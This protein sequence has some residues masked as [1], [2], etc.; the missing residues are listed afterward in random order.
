MVTMIRIFCV[1]CGL[2]VCILTGTPSEYQTLKDKAMSRGNEYSSRSL[3]V[4]LSFLLV[5]TN[6]WLF[7]KAH[8]DQSCDG[9]SASRLADDSMC[10]VL[11]D[12]RS[13]VDSRL[14]T[15]WLFR[16]KYSR[17]ANVMLVRC[18]DHHQNLSL[19]SSPILTLQ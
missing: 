16:T 14:W 6:F 10:K 2:G 7:P 1:S 13:H 18:L 9:V 8:S 15:I 4:P 5:F 12:H 3:P 17:V 11:S 19:C